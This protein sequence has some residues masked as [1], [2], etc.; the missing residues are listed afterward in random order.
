MNTS[1]VPFHPQTAIRRAALPALPIRSAALEPANLLRRPTLALLIRSNTRV[2]GNDLPQ[3]CRRRGY[4]TNFIEL[5]ARPDSSPQ[6]GQGTP[7][8]DSSRQ[9]AIYR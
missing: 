6:A 2:Y 4:G 5:C 1:V 8:L 9:A 3:A 7:H